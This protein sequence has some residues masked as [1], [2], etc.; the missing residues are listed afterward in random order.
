MDEEEGV[1]VLGEHNFATATDRFILM[2]AVF[3]I[4]GCDSC[5]ALRQEYLEAS[6]VLYEYLIPVAKVNVMRLSPRKI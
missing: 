4:P 6:N 2:L 1:L 5:A 3:H